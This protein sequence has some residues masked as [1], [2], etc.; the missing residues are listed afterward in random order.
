MNQ[1]LRESTMQARRKDAAERK[2][3]ILH[4]ELSIFRVPAI[5][6]S[7]SASNHHMS[8]LTSQN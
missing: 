4:V 7:F 8:L 5:N 2:N 3:S 1:L 6:E